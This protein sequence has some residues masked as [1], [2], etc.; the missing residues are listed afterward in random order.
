MS[1]IARIQCCSVRRVRS[2]SGYLQHLQWWYDLILP[3]LILEIDSPTAVKRLAAAVHT[4]KPIAGLLRSA[5]H[6]L[7]VEALLGD[8]RASLLSDVA[9]QQTIE[10]GV[11]AG[12]AVEWTA[13]TVNAKRASSK[14]VGNCPARRNSPFC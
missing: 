14:R 3:A 7:H 4:N 11:W 8:G 9:L 1:S 10:L 2:C 13:L 12:G 5:V 6:M